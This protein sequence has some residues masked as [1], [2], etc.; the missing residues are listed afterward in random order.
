MAIEIT[1]AR[2][3]SF[4]GII[5]KFTKPKIKPKEPPIIVKPIIYHGIVFRL[6]LVEI[7]MSFSDW[8]ILLK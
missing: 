5:F 6:I 1:K 4:I 8:F 3:V 2:L 7:L